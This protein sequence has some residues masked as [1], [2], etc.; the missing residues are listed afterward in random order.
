MHSATQTD[1]H[2][3]LIEQNVLY[4]CM[5]SMRTKETL[6][7]LKAAKRVVLLTGTPALS[8]P[9][10]LFPLLSGLVPSSKLTMKAFGERYCQL[11]DPWK[12]RW[13]GKY[14][15]ETHV[16]TSMLKL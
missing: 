12:Q 4:A 16:I 10:E 6:P 8:R 14:D 9:K 3:D 1:W 2:Q 15:G 7:I 5:Q 13:A 11:T